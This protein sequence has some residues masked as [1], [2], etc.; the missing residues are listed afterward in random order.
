M[1]TWG[2]KGPPGPPL[3]QKS[4]VDTRKTTAYPARSTAHAIHRPLPIIVRTTCCGVGVRHAG[5]K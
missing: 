5:G 3:L 2:P 1:R 4:L